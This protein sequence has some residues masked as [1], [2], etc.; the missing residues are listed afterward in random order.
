MS[1]I[2][3]KFLSHPS[4]DKSFSALIDSFDN[5]GIAL[6]FVTPSFLSLFKI[7]F[8]SVGSAWS[9]DM[10]LRLWPVSCITLPWSCHY[11]CSNYHRLPSALNLLDDYSFTP[12]LLS[13]QPQE[14]MPPSSDK[15]EFESRLIRHHFLQ[16]NLNLNP[17]SYKLFDFSE[18]VSISLSVKWKL[19][20]LSCIRQ[21]AI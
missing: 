14:Q 9:K 16:I 19:Y 6:A 4:D 15:P 3:H 20:C 13:P 17:G 7:L 21:V 11:V 18:L 2:R 8:S 1:S 5:I 12:L 10:P